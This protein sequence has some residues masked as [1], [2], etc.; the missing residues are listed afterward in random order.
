MSMLEES[1]VAQRNDQAILCPVCQIPLK[2]GLEGSG[3]V[4]FCPS[5]HGMWVDNLEEHH[6]LDLKPQVFTVDE[7]KRL[8]KFYHPIGED[9]P[10]RYIPCPVCK[11][12]MN[13]RNWGGHSGVVVNKCAEHGT[14]Y[15][16][17]EQLEN[18]QKY[19]ALG[20]IEYEKL[21][22]TVEG[23]DDVNYR[24]NQEVDKL[25]KD[26]NDKYARA[27]FYNFIGI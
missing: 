7:L 25:Q 8:H 12:L 9:H 13:L 18:I 19:I 22:L 3:E 16:S 1:P 26:I 10:K 27:R 6:V 21:Q 2:V 14:W 4:D 20:G 11:Q 17:K 5:C 23:L 15:S 24:L